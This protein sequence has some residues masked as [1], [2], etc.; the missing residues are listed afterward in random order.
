MGV[1]TFSPP[2]R[3]IDSASGEGEGVG[4][5]ERKGPRSD[6]SIRPSIKSTCTCLRGQCVMV[7]LEQG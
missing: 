7:G 2:G 5:R 1:A 4:R 3:V 6:L